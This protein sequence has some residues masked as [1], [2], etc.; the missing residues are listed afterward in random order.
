MARPGAIVLKFKAVPEA[1]TEV[2][3]LPIAQP[4][5]ARMQQIMHQI[6]T[7]H[8]TAH[9]MLWHSR[10]QDAPCQYRATRWPKILIAVQRTSHQLPGTAKANAR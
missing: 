2:R 7:G 8:C 9:D 4:H 1:K 5:I 10:A 3:A 6:R